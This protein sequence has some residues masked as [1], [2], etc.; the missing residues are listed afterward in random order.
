MTMATVRKVI[1]ISCAHQIPNHPGKCARPHGHNYKVE[2]WAT[3]PVDEETGMVLDFYLMKEDLEAVVGRWDHQDLNPMSMGEI[4][5][6]LGVIDNGYGGWIPTTAENLAGAWLHD[7]QQKSKL[8]NKIRVWE[9]EDSYAE[10][11][12]Q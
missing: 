1:T 6:I 4:C 5:S 12:S 8:Y 7:L 10:V 9:S 11:S 2:V 3:G